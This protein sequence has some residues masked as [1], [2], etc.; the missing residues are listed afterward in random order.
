MN[1]K[2]IL[3]LLSGSALC[4]AAPQY[5][6][7]AYTSY[8]ASPYTSYVSSPFSA[9]ASPIVYTNQVTSQLAY[10]ASPQVAGALVKDPALLSTRPNLNSDRF[11]AKPDVNGPASISTFPA[12]EPVHTTLGR[13]NPAIDASVRR[14][15]APQ[16]ASLQPATD[17]K[18]F[19]INSQYYAQKAFQF[20]IAVTSAIQ[21]VRDKRSPNAAAALAYMKAV[22]S[23]DICARSTQLYLEVI[24]QGGTVDEAN[25]AATKIYIDD[26]NNGLSV[27]PGSA[28]EASDVAWRKAEAEGKDPVVYSAI[29]FM[30][31]WPGMREGNPC[32]VSG[33]DYVNAIIEGAS[34]TQANFLAAKSFGDAIKN[35]AAQ[36]KELRDPACA[37]ATKAFFNALP[38]KPSPPNAAAMLAFIDKAYAGFSFNYDPV[39]WRSTEAFFDSYAA[40]NDELQSNRKAARVFL[41]EFAKGGAGIP[42]DSPCAAATRAY[43]ANI[44]NP[45]SPANKAAMEAF[46]DK[47]IADGPREPDPACAKS[48]VAYWDAYEAGATETDANLAAAEGF[49][50]A[51]TEGLHIPANSPCVAA[52]KAYFYNIPNKPSPPNAAA[53]I[54]FIDAMVAQ[55]NRRVYDPVCAKSTLAFWDSFK[56]GDDELTANFKA[57]LAFIEEYKK[58]AKVP[59]N[60]PC[61]IS[62]IAYSQAT[63]N[64]PSPPNNAAMLAF[65]EEAILSNMDRID[66]VCLTATEA[67]Y[68]AYLAGKG[69]TKSNEIAG[70][71]FLDAVAASPDFDPGSP[72]GISAKAYMKN[73][74]ASISVLFDGRSY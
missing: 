57:N 22:N 19:Q 61:L 47:M 16:I 10:A 23:Q 18:N 27:A 14:V 39:C 26:Y 38:S 37:A 12:P 49:F 28:C 13:S 33:R 50:K 72:C 32:A 62:T 24:L 69:E 53:M 20:P 52:T 1:P 51:F 46:M 17:H 5:S 67:Y 45:P 15:A 36:G 34:H 70:V 42:A 8:A 21:A 56:S 63:K 43:Y 35:L 68:R 3:C 6:Y 73:L 48:T 9:A 71:A 74:D 30:E 44:P 25:S 29:A 64:L 60:S 41:D 58:G 40:G 31:N 65:M 66:P 2:T 54:A 59:A 4:L 11:V 7:P 55:G